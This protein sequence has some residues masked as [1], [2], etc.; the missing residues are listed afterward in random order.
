MKYFSNFKSIEYSLDE[1][2]REFKLIK[3]PLIRLKLLKEIL[4]NTNIYYQY[5]MKGSDTYEIIA[6]KLYGDPNRYWMIAFGNEIVDPY[7]GAPLNFK[8]FD[9]YIIRKYGSI[10]TAQTTLHHYERITQITVDELGS[11]STKE[12]I[13]EFTPNTYNFKTKLI[14]PS[15]NIPTIGNSLILVEDLGSKTIDNSTIFT[16]IFHRFVSNYDFEEDENESKRNIRLL[17]PEYV[18]IIEEQFKNLLQR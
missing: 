7:F 15:T 2:N 12:Y 13:V 18:E 10:E 3:N 9:N 17:K 16:K 6:H 1:N 5:E 4:E 14:E 8:S 11:V